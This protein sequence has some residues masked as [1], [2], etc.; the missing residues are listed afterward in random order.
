MEEERKYE[1]LN[2]HYLR[3]AT[4]YVEKFTTLRLL[5]FEPAGSIWLDLFYKA[6]EKINSYEATP[7]FTKQCGA[8]LREN[9]MWVLDHLTILRDETCYLIPV[10]Q[11]G[12]L[13]NVEIDSMANTLNEFWEPGLNITI[14]NK[15]SKKLIHIFEAEYEYQLYIVD[16]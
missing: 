3:C 8:G 1:I 9:I 16:M 15:A 2:R 7:N 5:D 12:Y 11:H 10:K 14:A 6:F 13:A 4:K